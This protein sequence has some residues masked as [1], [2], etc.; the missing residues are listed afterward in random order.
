MQESQSFKRDMMDSI[1][2]TKIKTSRASPDI[3]NFT[4]SG[5]YLLFSFFK[6]FKTEIKSKQ[7]VFLRYRVFV[8]VKRSWI[9]EKQGSPCR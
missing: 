4:L 3:K 5:K 2:Q 9:S 1:L 7:I 8:P 6:A